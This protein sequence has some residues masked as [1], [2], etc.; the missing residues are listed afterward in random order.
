VQIISPDHS[1]IMSHESNRYKDDCYVP[2]YNLSNY[3][4]HVTYNTS[5]FH[6]YAADRTLVTWLMMVEPRHPVMLQVLRNIV[7]VHHHEYSRM[8]AMKLYRFDAKWKAVMCGTGPPLVTA[9]IRQEMLK[10]DLMAPD[11]HNFSITFVKKDFSEFGGVFKVDF[12]Q[13][14]TDG[15]GSHYMVYMNKH[16]V[17]LLATYRTLT[18][19][20]V[21]GCAVMD[22]TQKHLYFVKNYTRHSFPSYDTYMAMGLHLQYCVLLTTEEFQLIPLGG[23]L[24]ALDYNG[25]MM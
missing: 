2:A 3:H 5:I 13:S 22:P 25:P 23:T 14:F 7:H 16:N 24:P 9:T 15:E 21:E 10:R 17:Q 6:S 20:D 11:H 8:R 1:M 18:V 12:V 4:N 19:K